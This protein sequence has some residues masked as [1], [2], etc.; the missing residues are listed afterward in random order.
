M[1]FSTCCSVQFLLVQETGAVQGRAVV[2]QRLG[3]RLARI[4]PTLSVHV[5]EGCAVCL[6]A[7]EQNAFLAT[8]F[9][10]I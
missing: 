1:L 6:A 9:K 7:P 8:P 5:G 10:K 3:H 4:P 2:R